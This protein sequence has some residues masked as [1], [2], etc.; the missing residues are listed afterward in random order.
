MGTDS[1]LGFD[2]AIEISRLLI[3]D[4]EDT[5]TRLVVGWFG[6]TSI[7]AGSCKL[8]QSA[9]YW[10][11]PGECG[12]LLGDYHRSF[13]V[14]FHRRTVGGC[15]LVDISCQVGCGL[16]TLSRPWIAV[17]LQFMGDGHRTAKWS[18]GVVANTQPQPVRLTSSACT[19]SDLSSW[20]T[21]LK[22]QLEIVALVDSPCLSN[23]S[24]V[25]SQMLVLRPPSLRV[26]LPQSSLP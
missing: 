26:N 10:S 18:S 17:V 12:G 20:N 22:D 11:L 9:L 2:A 16:G 3:T 13:P 5:F 25:T 15:C 23:G 1:S 19:L 14:G 21:G 6:V 7:C 4:Q 24:C 8:D